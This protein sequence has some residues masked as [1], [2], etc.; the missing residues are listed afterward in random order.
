MNAFFRS[1]TVLCIG[2]LSAAACFAEVPND[3][4]HP[5]GRKEK[6]SAKEIEL[7]REWMAVDKT[8]SAGLQ[9][10]LDKKPRG[11]RHKEATALLPVAKKLEA[12]LSGAEKPTVS[13]P[14][15]TY[16][17]RKTSLEK[18]LAVAVSYDK[19]RRFGTDAGAC[20]SYRSVEFEDASGFTKGVHAQLAY[21]A[22]PRT[23]WAGPGSILAFDSGGEQCPSDKLPVV[24]TGKNNVVYFGVV[25]GMGYVHLN[26]EGRLVY[27]DG[28][29]VPLR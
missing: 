16:G 15:E 23:C 22:W 20:W 4:R 13:I 3:S 29:I 25:E 8:S 2:I 5:S 12:I 17:E 19:K 27:P 14:F 1:V 10:Y 21:A 18:R 11:S 28:K 9:A 26:G 7:E 24:V 6:P